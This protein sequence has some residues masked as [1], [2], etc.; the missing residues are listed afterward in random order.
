MTSDLKI[1]ET[2]TDTT[3]DSVEGY[4]T[5][6]SLAKTPELASILKEQADKRRQLVNE[7]NAEVSRLGGTA[8]KSGSTMGAAHRVWT[9]ISDAFSRGDEKATER[10]EEGED[11]LEKKFR[12]ALEHSDLSP[13]TRSVLTRVHE[14]IAEGERLSD[15]LAEQYD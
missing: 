4:E 14:K 7:L 1:V 15:R 6:A 5:A 12:E 11:Y 13:E 3:I 8:R 10:V 2:L 9:A